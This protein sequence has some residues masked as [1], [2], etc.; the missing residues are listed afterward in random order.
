[1]LVLANRE[2][3]TFD[4]LL[5]RAPRGGAGKGLRKRIVNLCEEFPPYG[6]ALAPTSRLNWIIP[7]HWHTVC[8]NHSVGGSYATPFENNLA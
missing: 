1:M 7:R 4:L 8:Y 3:G 2:A 5:P 6:R